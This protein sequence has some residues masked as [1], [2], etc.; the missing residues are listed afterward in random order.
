[1]RKRLLFALFLMSSGLTGAWADELSEKQAQELARSFVNSHLGRKGGGS[2]LKSPGQVSELK[3]LGQVSGLYVFSMSEKGGFVIVSNESRTIPIL[4]YSDSGTFDPDDMP[5]NMRAWLQGYADEIA[6]LQKQGN[7][8]SEPADNSTTRA[9]K[10]DQTDIEPLISTTWD[11]RYPYNAYCHFNGMECATGCIATAM[12]QVMYYTERKAG[13]DTT[14]TT[15]TIPAYTTITHKFNIPEIPAESPI[16][17][18][19]MRTDYNNS[20]TTEEAKAVATLMLYCGCSIKMDYDTESGGF[21]SNIPNAL[22]SY[23]GYSGTTIYANRS[24]YSYDNWTDLIYHE[25]AQGR[26]IVYGG[27]SDGGGHAFVCDGY[28]YEDYTDLFHINWGWNG[29]SDGYF[30]LSALKPGQQGTGGSSSTDGYHYGQEAVIGIQKIGGTGTVLN[31][32]TNNYNLTINSISISHSTIALGESVDVTLNVTN[33]GE[34]AY[35]GDLYLLKDGIAFWGRPFYIPAGTTQDCVINYT[36]TDAGSETLCSAFY[37]NSG[38][39]DGNESLTVTLNTVD[40]TPKGL[41]NTDMTSTEATI[42]WT[43][44]GEAT[45]WNL[46]SRTT[47]LSTED[48]NGDVT[49]RVKDNNIDGKTWGIQPTSGI[50][51]TP[52]FAS[53]SYINDTALDPFDWLITPLFTLGGSISF[54]AWGKDERFMVLYSTDFFNY[55]PISS[56]ITTTEA[57]Q[58]YIFDLSNYG[59]VE[60]LIAIIH[61]NSSG[62]TSESYLYVDDVTFSFPTSEWVKT[63]NVTN[64]YRLRGLTQDTYYEVQAQAVIKDGGKWS[65]TFIFRT[66][67]PLSVESAAGN[68]W[69]TDH[70]GLTGYK[71]ADRWYSLDGCKLSGKPSAKGV[72]VNNGRKLVIK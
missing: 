26:A 48:F 43:N 49:W 65:D 6:W 58:L 8:K 35:D 12:A 18:S 22:M 41:T 25:L 33:S 72:Y 57:A 66:P 67:T 38:N 47:T 54:Y 30:V 69:T 39:L 28:K 71:T 46:R 64:P 36:P 27:L 37:N 63:C 50:N 16:N 13:N 51:G 52:C 60:G 5:T 24:H 29:M 7:D 3:S 59:N 2:I 19:I 20:Y 32:P 9:G 45:N 17:W 53:P 4:G 56:L 70:N 42:G 11:Q 40:Q 34:D 31:V 44:V 23:F 1:M 61:M 14:T 10:H 15:D 21:I 55:N 68:Y 62:H